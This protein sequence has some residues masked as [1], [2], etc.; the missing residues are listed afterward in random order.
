VLAGTTVVDSES[1]GLWYWSQVGVGYYGFWHV[2]FW[3]NPLSRAMV[4]AFEWWIGLMVVGGCA[5]GTCK[6]GVGGAVA[7]VWERLTVCFSS[8]VNMLASLFVGAS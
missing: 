1:A 3:W 6:C 4:G 2:M 7:R 5:V 8:V